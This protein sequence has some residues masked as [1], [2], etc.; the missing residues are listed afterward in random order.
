MNQLR[1]ETEEIHVRD[2]LVAVGGYR[3]GISVEGKAPAGLVLLVPA[4]AIGPERHD[5]FSKRLWGE[6]A[7]E[8]EELDGGRVAQA[9]EHVI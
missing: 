9:E 4:R 5:R 3:P 8:V 1:V 7:G 6:G 2:T